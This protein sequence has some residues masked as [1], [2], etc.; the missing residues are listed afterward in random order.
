MMSFFSR[1]IFSTR[2]ESSTVKAILTHCFLSLTKNILSRVGRFWSSGNQVVN[3]P[4]PCSRHFPFQMVGSLTTMCLI[5]AN[6]TRFGS[7]VG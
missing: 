6:A 2:L 7:R 1:K 5:S 3:D 4:V